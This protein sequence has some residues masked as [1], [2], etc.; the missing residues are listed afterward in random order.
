MIRPRRSLLYVPGDDWRKITKAAT[1]G[2]DCVC[3]DMEDGVALNRKDAARTT[4]PKA[5][6]ELD[7]GRAERLVRINAIGSGLEEEDLQAALQVIPDGIVI[8]KVESPEQLDWAEKRLAE[9]ERRRGLPHGTLR[10]WIGI[11]T[12]RAILNLSQLAA[13]PRLEVLIF[14]SEDLAA[15]LGATRTPQA[16]EVF[17][18]RSAVVLAAAAFGLQAID[19][20]SIELQDM[21]RVRAEAIFGAQMGYSGKQIIHPNQVAPVHEAFTPSAEAVAQAQRVIEAYEAH[22]REGKGAF[23][24]DGKMIDLP[25]VKAARNVLARAGIGLD[26]S[27][28]A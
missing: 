19:M 5:L 14:G 8:P 16:W 17:Y 4:I 21:E 23:A 20:V 25:L 10:L 7:F 2:V 13:H 18:A 3:L 27:F 24:L 9:E 22:L 15:A 26:P 28:S 1:L 11:E 6:A 12:P